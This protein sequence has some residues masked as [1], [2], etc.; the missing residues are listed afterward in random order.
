MI[1][2]L[3]AVVWAAHVLL[4]GSRVKIMAGGFA[5]AVV[6][7]FVWRSQTV[8][9]NPLLEKTASRFLV[10]LSRVTPDNDTALNNLGVDI[11]SDGSQ[12]RRV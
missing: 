9:S 12:R 10:A 7:A 3:I 2:L 1:G 11:L 6:L 4:S 8:F 5:T